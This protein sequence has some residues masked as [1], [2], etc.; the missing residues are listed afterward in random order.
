MHDVGSDWFLQYLY[1]RAKRKGYIAV[2]LGSSEVPSAYIITWHGKQ[3][4]KC[5]QRWNETLAS[6][7]PHYFWW[8][9]NQWAA[10]FLLIDA[11]RPSNSCWVHRFCRIIKPQ[12]CRRRACIS[13][14]RIDVKLFRLARRVGSREVDWTI[15]IWKCARRT[16]T[17]Q[18]F[19]GRSSKS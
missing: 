7:R 2:L 16:S 13:S 17:T 1:L 19:P 4:Q 8:T 3:W 14:W 15:E 5:G 10:L 11:P 6:H 18:V 9:W 12:R